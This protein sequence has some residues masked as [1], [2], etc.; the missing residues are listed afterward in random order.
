[1]R[2]LLA[3][4]EVDDSDVMTVVG[5]LRDETAQLGDDQYDHAPEPS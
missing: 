5:V 2:R 3:D 4:R 1:M